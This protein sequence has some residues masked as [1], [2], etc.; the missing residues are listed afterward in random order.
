MPTQQHI[1]SH[2]VQ[3]NVSTRGNPANSAIVLVHG[4][5]DNQQVWKAVAER[6]A[7][8]WFVVTY[9]VRG[10]GLSD[11]PVHSRDYRMS[12]LA[13]D[14][15]AVVNAVLPDR[16][17]HLVGHDW[18]SIQSWESVTGG[19]I[20]SRILSYTTIS[21]PCL[22]HIGHWLRTRLRHPSPRHFR[23]LAGQL[24]SSWY[25]GAFHLPWL[26]P[27]LW[28][29]LLGARWSGYLKSS[30][31]IANVEANP[32]QGQDGRDGI[33]LY[34]A[35]IFQHLLFPRVRYARCPVQ[36]I[37]PTDDRYVGSQLFEGLEDW[38]PALYQ[39]EIQRGHWLPLSQPGVVA[40]YIGEFARH[41]ESS[42]TCERLAACRLSPGR[43][44]ADQPRGRAKKF[45]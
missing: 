18:G 20:Q 27:M 12:L 3:L 2:G 37:V 35:N 45:A 19:P 25:I 16:T 39:R 23:Q 41:M 26:A 9:D 32:Y 33:R 11:R 42:Q 44:A 29:R 38:V 34:R 31:G 4:Y 14:L 24:A 17:F 6:L 43:S 40:D 8:D 28:N 22:D 1:Q 10:A 30:E 5:P 15:E 13:T 7:G 36:L 21:G